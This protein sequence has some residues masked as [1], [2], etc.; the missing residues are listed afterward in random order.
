MQ[1]ITGSLAINLCK[2]LENLLLTKMD[3]SFFI[4]FSYFHEK[5]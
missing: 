4:T 5:Y 3:D 2:K 1:F